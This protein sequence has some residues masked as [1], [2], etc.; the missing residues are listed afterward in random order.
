MQTHDGFFAGAGMSDIGGRA[1]VGLGLGASTIPKLIN[2]GFRTAI[3]TES[4]ASRISATGGLSQ[5]CSSR[6]FSCA[7]MQVLRNALFLAYGNANFTRS[8]FLKH[9]KSFEDADDH[10]ATVG[11]TSDARHAEAE[12]RHGG[13]AA[14]EPAA[15]DAGGRRDMQGRVCVVTGGNQGIGRAAATA[16]AQRALG[17]PLLPPWLRGE[18]M[19]HMREEGGLWGG[20]AASSFYALPPIPPGST[21]PPSSFPI[22]FLALSSSAS[23]LF[24]ATILRELRWTQCVATRSEKWQSLSSFLHPPLFLTLFQSLPFPHFPP[25]PLSLPLPVPPSPSPTTPQTTPGEPRWT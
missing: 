14:A 8:A 18:W 3:T 7:I 13:A 23:S 19:A 24:P 25:L 22:S 1:L 9:A 6:L 12:A 21:P 5:P 17:V 10:A 20:G 4:P 16:M 15:T 2:F 11:V